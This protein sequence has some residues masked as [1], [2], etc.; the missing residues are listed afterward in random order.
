MKPPTSQYF[1]P[2]AACRNTGRATTNQTS[3]A[4]KRKKRARERTLMPF[5]LENRAV[6]AGFSF[7]RPISPGSTRVIRKERNRPAAMAP[8]AALK[9]ILVSSNPPM[10]KPTPLRAFLEPVRIATHWNSWFSPRLGS[11]GVSGTTVLMA[12][13]ALILLRSLAMPLIAWATIT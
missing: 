11:P 1:Q 3:R 8:T 7:M 13:L 4:P 10:K 2:R 12:L 6:M 5:D 9:P